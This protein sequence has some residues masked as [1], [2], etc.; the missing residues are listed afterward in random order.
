MF[1]RA[2]T[3]SIK[4]NPK[5]EQGEP[6]NCPSWIHSLER[7]CRL[8]WSRWGTDDF[9]SWVTR[10]G[11]YSENE[12]AI[13]S[14][15]EELREEEKTAQKSGGQHNTP[16][17]VCTRGSYLRLCKNQLKLIWNNNIQISWRIK[18]SAYHHSQIGKPH[19]S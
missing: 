2:W 5:R 17:S 14:R 9:I 10:A 6:Y 19:C 7:V 13:D 18:N 4:S 12:F 8:Q 11:T 16:V 15:T 1:L 3:W